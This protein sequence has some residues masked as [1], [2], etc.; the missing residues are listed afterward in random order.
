[1][2]W[3]RSGSTSDTSTDCKRRV[4]G[5]LW[6]AE[7][8]QLNS[9]TALLADYLKNDLQRIVESANVRLRAIAEA[10]LDDRVR[11]AEETRVVNVARAFAVLRVESTVRQ[12]R[13]EPLGF[14]PELLQLTG[15][16]GR[17]SGEGV[18][19]GSDVEPL[20]PPVGGPLMAQPVPV[21]PVGPEGSSGQAAVEGVDHDRPTREFVEAPANST[22]T[23]GGGLLGSAEQRLNRLVEFVARQEPRLRWAAGI[24]D[25]GTT[26]LTTDLADGWIPPGINLPEAAVLLTPRRRTGS[27]AAMLG[28]T[29][30]TASYSP[31]DRFGSC[32]TRGQPAVSTAA[33][34]LGDIDDLPGRLVERTHSRDGLPR[35]THTLVST[36]AS[37]G[38][39]IDAE[40]D[41]LR[42]HL[43][44]ARYRLLADY[45][46]VDHGLLL[47][48]LLLAA[49]EAW[50]TDDTVSANYH[51]AWFMALS[52]SPTE[53][54]PAPG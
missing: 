38:R 45:P 12:L 54:R 9:E 20:E 53:A 4:L 47:N 17:S 50:V 18:S 28:G 29:A 8:D 27:A 48:C 25:D 46:G 16:Q 10:G 44:T 41:V 35:L 21:G 14:R 7:L 23:E 42:V 19:A 22:V 37:G 2:Q 5:G 34:K 6:P 52:G 31:G 15:P 3:A 30:P 51:F 39:V 26:L 32:V 24:R 40:V 11:Q 49:A 13:R 36:V 1:M 43:D 33:R